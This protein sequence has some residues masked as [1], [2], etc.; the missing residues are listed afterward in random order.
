MT[1]VVR[2]KKR[3]E[4]DMISRKQINKNKKKFRKTAKI[5]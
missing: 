5:P 3:I 1:S 4:N 2:Q